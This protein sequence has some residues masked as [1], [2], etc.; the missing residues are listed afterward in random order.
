MDEFISAV[1]T[2]LLSSYYVPATELGSGD[3]AVNK[4]KSLLH[5]ASI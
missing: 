5:G 2:Y 3:I 4:T 1:N